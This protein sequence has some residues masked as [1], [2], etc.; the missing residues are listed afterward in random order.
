MTKPTSSWDEIRLYLQ[1]QGYT[2]AASLALAFAKDASFDE[3]ALLFD[4]MQTEATL[5]SNEEVQRIASLDVSDEQEEEIVELENVPELCIDAIMQLSMHTK[6]KAHLAI[7]D[8]AVGILEEA[9]S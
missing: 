4:A 1:D 9:L 5:R 7:L 3:T 6:N 8:Q 2:I